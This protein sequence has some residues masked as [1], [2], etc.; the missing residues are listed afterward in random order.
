MSFGQFSSV[1]EKLEIYL[2]VKPVPHNIKQLTHITVPVL[3]VVQSVNNHQQYVF[4][5]IIMSGTIST[6]AFVTLELEVL[7]SIITPFTPITASPKTIH[8]G[9]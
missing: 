7:I 9:L 8:H 4:N 1:L 6:E 5:P 3:M 2:G